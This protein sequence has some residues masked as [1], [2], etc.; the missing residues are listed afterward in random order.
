MNLLDVMLVVVTLA[1]GLSGYWQGFLTGAAATGG[2]LVGGGTGIVIAPY[3]LGDLTPSVGVALA[4]LFGVL[5]LAALGQ[6]L[7][8]YAGSRLRNG[9]RWRPARWLDA[10]GGAALSMAAVLTVAWA[11]GYAVSGA[12]L[13]VVADAVR[14][15]AVLSRIDTVMPDSADAVLG[16]FNQIVDTNLFPRY[17]EPFTPERIVAVDTPSSRVLHRSG[18]E[19]AGRS[20]VKVLGESAECGRAIE[21]S[22]F[23]YAPGRV[24]TNAHVVAGVAD[25]VVMLGE[26]RYDAT[27]VVYDPELDVAVLAVDALA[28]P[29][30]RFDTSARTA[31]SAAVLGYPQNGPYNAE[32]AR[33]RSKQRLS[34]PDIYGQSKVTR[35]VYSV[36]SK[37][38]SG[39]SGG[40][41]VSPR[42]NVY[43]VVFAASLTDSATGYALTAAQVAGDARSGRKATSEVTTGG[44]A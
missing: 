30:L 18:V 21:G 16:A 5:L 19:Q 6:A 10:V 9:I 39:N 40:P 31:S 37:V 43:G 2:L 22:G 38:R 27:V 32:P 13:P 34:S 35:Q 8:A 42:G 26:Q 44:C 17:L 36:R 15:S 24:M 29:G 11:L 7:G 23:V 12:R 4:A 41:L 33:I 3:V 1:Y 20:V 14:S 28:A 25:P